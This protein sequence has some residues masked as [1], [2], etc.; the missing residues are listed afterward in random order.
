MG[1]IES[2]RYGWDPRNE[3]VNF[4]EC[5][6]VFPLGDEG[7]FVALGSFNNFNPKMYNGT[8]FQNN[9]YWVGSIHNNTFLPAYRGVLDFGMYYAARSGSTAGVTQSPTARRVRA[10]WCYRMG[11]TSREPLPASHFHAD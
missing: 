8:T 9:E 6:D 1:R 5:P 2:H 7:L 11:A 3:P 10:V 4:I